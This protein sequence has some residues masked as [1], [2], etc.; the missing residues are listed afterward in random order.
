MASP[1]VRKLE[2]PPK[3]TIYFVTATK[4]NARV[5]KIRYVIER[6]IAHFKTW[7]ILHA[8]YGRPIVT[9]EETISTVVGLHFYANG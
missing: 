7:R 1:L 3:Q 5:N 2:P 9:F 4:Y 6:M 8:D